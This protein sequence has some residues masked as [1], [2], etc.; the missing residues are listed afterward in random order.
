MSV[1]LSL[2]PDY[3]DH[4]PFADWLSGVKCGGFIDDDGTGYYATAT[5]MSNIEAIPSETWFQ[6]LETRY[7]FDRDRGICKS[8]LGYTHVMWFN[9]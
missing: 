1:K 4:M 3:G 6:M 5:E 2:L 7:I 8:L 9:K